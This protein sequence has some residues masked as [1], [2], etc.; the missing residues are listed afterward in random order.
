MLTAV[1][2]VLLVSVLPSL[3][4]RLMKEAIKNAPKQ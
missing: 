1:A 3:S 4:S 2:D